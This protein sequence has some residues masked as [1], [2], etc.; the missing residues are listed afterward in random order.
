MCERGPIRKVFRR[1]HGNESS[2]RQAPL[3]DYHPVPV[4]HITAR[5][6]VGSPPLTQRS[7]S[8]IVY[9]AMFLILH[10]LCVEVF[11]PAQVA[12]SYAFMFVAP[13]IAAIAC[14]RW[15]LRSDPRLRLCGIQI[16]AGLSLWIAGMGLDAW[17]VF[18]EHATQN[19]ALIPDL[20]YF[21]YGVPILYAISSSTAEHR[22]RLFLWLY[23][24]QAAAIAYL[25]Y[26]VLFASLPFTGMTAAPISG[27]GLSMAFLVENLGL[28]VASTVRLFSCAHAQERR[29]YRILSAFL[30]IY[31]GCSTLYNFW[32]DDGYG[33]AGVNDLVI[34]LPFLI[35]AWCFAYA[36]IRADDAETPRKSSAALFIASA[37][38]V[39]FTFG[40]L[41]LGTVVMQ[42]YFAIGAAGVSLGLACY[43][44]QATLLQSRYLDAQ[45]SLRAALDRLERLS[46][47][48]GLTGI[49]N[50]RCFDR[51]LE[52]EWSRAQRSRR[53]LSLMLID[54]DFFKNLNDRYGH[55]SGDE[56]L[57]AIAHTLRA[58]LP[59]ETDL[60][61]RYGGDEFAAILPDTGRPGAAMVGRKMA[62][63]VRRLG[64]RN[65]TIIGDVATISVGIST[66]ERTGNASCLDLLKG[67]DH[68]LYR[69]KQHGRDWVVSY[70]VDEIVSV[71]R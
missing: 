56:C 4:L 10:A 42:R 25:A 1:E 69:A 5:E 20:F 41:A 9:G 14:F 55:V 48:D 67:S 37:S 40:M 52:S 44:L 30:W 15:V 12:V 54:L 6:I 2:A 50:R 36:P 68:A 28:A 16:A 7:R 61:A 22:S 65:E 32:L 13:L 70:S 58:A 35:L 60:L 49:A 63:A 27:D 57:V 53:P 3:P 18:V 64:I 8:A 17:E 19:S 46:M 38:P 47:T 29:L 26:V 71:Q 51:T 59:R 39:F 34:D 23:G 45:Q 31:L 66:C 33:I 11:R 24:L 21:F 62:S 43:G